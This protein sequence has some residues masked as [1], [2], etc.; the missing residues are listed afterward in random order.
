MTLVS[1]SGSAQPSDVESP[2]GS[3]RTEAGTTA[4]LFLEHLHAGNVADAFQMFAVNEKMPKPFLDHER[5]VLERISGAAKAGTSRTVFIEVRVEG[6]GAVAV[7]NESVKRGKPSFDLD[8]LYLVRLDGTWWIVPGE[9][10]Y[11]PVSVLLPE[12]KCAVFKTL[13]AWFKNR[14][15]EL[16]RELRPQGR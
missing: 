10:E 14:K 12:E 4:K 16:W 13:E 6:M 5:S 2:G 11:A 15:Q 9:T 7:V 3:A 1:M 8:P